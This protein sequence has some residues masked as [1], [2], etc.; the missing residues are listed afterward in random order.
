M[1][2]DTEE[3]QRWKRDYRGDWY[4]HPEGEYVRFSD[5]AER[6][7]R[8]KARIKQTSEA[9]EWL[10]DRLNDTRDYW[11]GQVEPEVDARWRERIEAK[12]RD[13]DK[14]AAIDEKESR[15]SEDDHF[16]SE[17]Y[18]M[19]AARHRVRA[20][21]LRSLLDSGEERECPDCAGEEIRGCSRCDGSG[22]A[23]TPSPAFHREGREQFCPEKTQKN[24]TTDGRS[25]PVA[26]PEKV[27]VNRA[28]LEL[29]LT[30]TDIYYPGYAEGSDEPSGLPERGAAAEDRLRAALAAFRAT[31]TGGTD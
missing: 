23:T 10:T 15:T 5:V 17:T 18:S 16:R 20:E 24:W 3:L 7:A 28:D 6:E 25:A 12:A 31:D 11:R 14:W 13:H 19:R 30:D 4:R 2:K 9:N 21:T 26:V 22:R 1:G 8:L 29:I 27:E